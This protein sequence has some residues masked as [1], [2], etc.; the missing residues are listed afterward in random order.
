LTRRFPYKDFYNEVETERKP[1]GRY[2]GDKLKEAS[3][4][5]GEQARRIAGNLELF[6][7]PKS[8]ILA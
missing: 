7:Y 4:K 8:K 3:G 5:A 2:A 6:E 1:K